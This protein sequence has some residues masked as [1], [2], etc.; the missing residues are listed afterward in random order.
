MASQ[1]LPPTLAYGEARV[2]RPYLPLLISKREE[3][4]RQRTGPLPSSPRILPPHLALLH[5]GLLA[6]RLH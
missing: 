3:N 1:Y 2:P 6:G 5:L 4:H